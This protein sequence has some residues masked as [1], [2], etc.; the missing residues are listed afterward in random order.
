MAE[1]NDWTRQLEKANSRKEGC[2]CIIKPKYNKHGKEDRVKNNKKDLFIV[3]IIS[4]KDRNMYSI[5]LLK[6]NIYLYVYNVK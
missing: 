2:I 5:I 4:F 6:H 1:V 3:N